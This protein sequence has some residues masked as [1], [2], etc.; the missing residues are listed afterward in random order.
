MVYTVRPNGVLRCVALSSLTVLAM[1]AYASD[2]GTPALKKL[3]SDLTRAIDLA[4]TSKST[5]TEALK[6]SAPQSIRDGQIQV[7]AGVKAIT[8]ELIKSFG[9]LGFEVVAQVEKDGLA[10]VVARTSDPLAL[11]VLAGR[12]DVIGIVPEPIA[13]LNAGIVDNQADVSMRSDKVKQPMGIDGT[14][15]R[16]G[17][18][19][20]SI[21]NSIGGI[22]SNGFLTGSTPQNSGD[23]PVSIRVIDPGPLSGSDEGAGMLEL[24]HDVAPGAD[25]SF[26]SAVTSYALFAGNITSLATD[27]GRECDVI[28]DDVLYPLE[29]VYQDGPIAVAANQAVQN[30]AV[31]FSSAGNNLD[32]AHERTYVD[33]NPSVLEDTPITGGNDLHDFG[34]AYGMASDTHLA[35]RVNAGGEVSVIVHWDEPYGGV[36]APGPGAE[37]DIDLYLTSDT[38]LPIQDS[39][40][41]PGAIGVNDNVYEKSSSFQGTPGQPSG[42]AVEG[43]SYRNTTPI[44]Q[45][46][47][48][49]VD[50]FDG[51]RPVLLN[52]YVRTT[53]AT[54]LD[55]SL[56]VD[57]TLVS[58][59]AARD[60]HAVAAV[61]YGEVDQNGN[62]AN[63]PGQLDVETFS[64]L[65]GNL[66]YFFPAAGT[67]RFGVPELRFKP[68][69]TA[70]DGSNT[71]FFGGDIAFDSDTRPNFFGTSAAAPH[72]AAIAALMKSADGSL[73]PQEIYTI[74]QQTAR[75]AETPG[76]DA[77]S[78][79]GVIDGLE[80][81]RGVL[82]RFTSSV[83]NWR[84][85]K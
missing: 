24:I 21:K 49:V 69:I 44:Q 75:D 59:A 81:V 76:L 46:A 79:H 6:I 78:G 20:D 60:V 72:A 57:R 10:Q 51:R 43:F 50:H 33:V 5:G 12:G 53:G 77:L 54:I 70:P 82:G 34:A 56:M 37:A 11:E 15:V 67:P 29:P 7:I 16:V 14:G 23:L 62:L 9:D 28:V 27:A 4:R 42:D 25:L 26:A 3:S 13:F 52:V 74:L 39:N 66:A 55:K 63:P 38:S 48:I 85:Y 41:L 32:N 47:H 68:E 35:V 40:S 18:L 8:P 58:H 83:E 1:S 84:A 65:G 2:P 30:G 31:Y 64:A 36:L 73:T 61:F 71:T 80:A 19:S 22:L 17:V 45:V